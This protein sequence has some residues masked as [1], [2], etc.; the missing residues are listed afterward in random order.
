MVPTVGRF[1]RLVSA[2]G[3]DSSSR[4]VFYDQKGL[5]S[6]ARGWWMFRLFGHERVYVLDGGLPKWLEEERPAESG[7]VSTPTHSSGAAFRATL[8]TG[9]LRGVGDVLENLQTR[10]EMVVDARARARFEGAVPEPRAGISSGHIPGSVNL[11]FTS[12]LSADHTF[13]DAGALRGL[14][15]QVGVDGTTPLIASCGTGV[16]AA[17]VALGAE[18]AGFAPVALYDGSWTEWGGRDDT[19]KI[20]NIDR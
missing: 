1:E 13:R 18:L 5:F 12:L 20:S 15:A 11:P 2:L 10:R 14:F 6:A 9:L 17:V 16:T 3:V 7:P 4:V 19:P 8:R